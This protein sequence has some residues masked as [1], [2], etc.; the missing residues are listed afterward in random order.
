MHKFRYKNSARR[1]VLQKSCKNV[2]RSGTGLA[3]AKIQ[4]QTDC[5]IKSIFKIGVWQS[6]TYISTLMHEIKYVRTRTRT[7]AHVLVQSVLVHD[8]QTFAP[9][10]C[11][12][13]QNTS[14]SPKSG[15]QTNARHFSKSHINQRIRAIFCCQTIPTRRFGGTL[16]HV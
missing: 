7:H 12:Y 8:L 9:S 14:G 4:H 5:L 6:G 3:L 16:T 10:R 13:W 2:W 11:Y 1:P 15:C